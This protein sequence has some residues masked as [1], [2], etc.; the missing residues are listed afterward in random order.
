[1]VAE[2]PYFMENKEWYYFDE[3]E[4]KYKLTD[5]AP[6]KAKESYKE[7]Y[8]EVKNGKNNRS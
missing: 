3:I 5:K 1:M 8:E 2:Q 4:F 7:F 6:E